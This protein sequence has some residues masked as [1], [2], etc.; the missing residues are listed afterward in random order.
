MM[1]D[2]FN[3]RKFPRVSVRCEINVQ[4]LRRKKKPIAAFTENIGSGGVC[5]MLQKE[6]KR[7]TSCRLS[8]ELDEKL[9]KI[10]S[11]ARIVW[12]V[13]TGKLKSRKSSYDTGIEF[14]GLD[15]NSLSLL[16]C[17][18]AKQTDKKIP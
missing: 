13:P 5:V 3:K 11:P 6:L 4:T 10:E 12:T 15:E 7:F 9:P 8:L 14:T 18:I 16:N 2:G 17:F 1:W